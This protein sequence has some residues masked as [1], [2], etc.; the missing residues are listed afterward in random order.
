MGAG[1]GGERGAN[2]LPIKASGE[3]LPAPPSLPDSVKSLSANVFFRLEALGEGSEKAAT[4]LGD[5]LGVNGA[6]QR[7]SNKTVTAAS[8]QGIRLCL[9][10]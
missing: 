2:A 7:S 10:V 8:S 9:I 3:S 4:E 1:V 6:N 5:G